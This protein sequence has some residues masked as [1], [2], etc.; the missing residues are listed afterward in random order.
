MPAAVTLAV[1]TA[2]SAN[3]V[4]PTRCTSSRTAGLTACSPGSFHRGGFDDP[5]AGPRFNYGAVAL[6]WLAAERATPGPA[7]D[8][9]APR[10]GREPAGRHAG[11]RAG[12]VPG[13]DRG[14]GVAAALGVAARPGVA[15][16]PRRAPAGVHGPPQA[17]QPRP[18]QPIRVATQTSSSSMPSRCWSWHGGHPLRTS[19]GVRA[20]DP[21]DPDRGHPTGCAAS[22][23]VAP[24]RRSDRRRR[25]SDPVSIRRATR[26]AYHALSCAMVMRAIRLLDVVP[27]PRRTGRAPCALG[28][29]CPGGPTRRRDVDGTWYPAGLDV[30]R[31]VY[32]ALAGAAEFGADD[33]ALAARLRRLAEL[34]VRRSC[35]RGSAPPGSHS[36]QATAAPAAGLDHSADTIVCNGLALTFLQLAIGEADAAAGSTAPLPAEVPGAGCWTRTPPASQRSAPGASGSP[37]TGP[38]RTRATRA[39]TPASSR[40]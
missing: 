16:R 8:S 13:L 9:C 29:D 11:H 26:C 24:A 40:R 5:L 33:P 35:E 12:S 37:S 4:T 38:P 25:R 7:G 32:A 17:R 6:G 22:R 27:A 3:A 20:A 34:G 28:A 23:D 31:S 2:P 21:A 10:G 36:A 14:A 30:R 18:V 15:R 19:D 1:L 39:T